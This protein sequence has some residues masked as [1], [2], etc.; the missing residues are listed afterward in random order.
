M[1]S[2][3]ARLRSSGLPAPFNLV[4]H[5][6][7]LSR[8]R[9]I[10][11]SNRGLDS[12]RDLLSRDKTGLFPGCRCLVGGGVENDVDPVVAPLETVRGKDTGAAVDV[13]A[14]APDAAGGRSRE[15]TVGMAVPRHA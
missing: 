5:A 2:V 3:A 4:V 7:Y 10:L 14:V 6:L 1:N 9:R 8:N 11:E 12:E 15:R 13:N